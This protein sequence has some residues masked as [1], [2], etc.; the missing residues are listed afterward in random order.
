MDYSEKFKSESKYR[1]KW[2]INLISNSYENLIF[3]QK[4]KHHN[5]NK[6]IVI[7]KEP[8]H[9]KYQH[10]QE[11]K[12]VKGFV[13]NVHGPT[14][15]DIHFELPDHI[16][17]KYNNVIF[18]KYFYKDIDINYDFQS[19]NLLSTFNVREGK[20]YR[21]RLRGIGIKKSNTKSFTVKSNLFL[22]EIK[23]LIDRSDLW[24]RCDLSDIDIYKRLLIDIIIDTKTGPINLTDYLLNRIKSDD[25]PIFFEYI[26]T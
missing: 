22:M 25:D 6:K 21:C 24:I 23:H 15:F 1:S 26:K 8:L 3:S 2:D 11:I 10:L 7:Y 9:S 18:H 16:I 20:A 12:N 17:E 14:D 5:Y 19:D 4:K 13:V